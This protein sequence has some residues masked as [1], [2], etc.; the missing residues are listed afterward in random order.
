MRAVIAHKVPGV[1]L[2]AISLAGINASK[3]RPPAQI[4]EGPGF[5]MIY[6]CGRIAGNRITSRMVWLLVNSI[7][8]RSIPIPR[9]AVGGRPYSSAVM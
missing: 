7:T 3:L 2:F 6:F 4:N 8:I 9:P 1:S 5:S